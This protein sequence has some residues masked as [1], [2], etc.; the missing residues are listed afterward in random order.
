MGLKGKL[1]E[2]A[3]KLKAEIIAV[4]YACK[5]PRLGL[6]PKV[7]ILLTIGYALSPI[8]LIPDFIPILGLLDDLIILPAMI[9]LSLKLIPDE[10][11]EE[12]RRLAD[13]NDKSLP[14]NRGAAVVIILIWAAVLYYIIISIIHTAL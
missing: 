13:D 8:D 11:M 14:S 4:Y 7:I 10:I 9:S 3:G 6:L 5:N 2:R 1:I 12:A